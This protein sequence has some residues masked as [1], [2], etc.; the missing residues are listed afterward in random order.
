MSKAKT[1]TIVQAYDGT[2]I[3]EIQLHDQGT[4]DAILIRASDAHR[5]HKQG[6]P[7]YPRIEILGRLIGLMP[8]HTDELA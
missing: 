8:S 6:L 2:T 4:V 3:K 7:A 5:N 1:L